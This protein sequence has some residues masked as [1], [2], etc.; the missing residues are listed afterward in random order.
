MTD[1]KLQQYFAYK[2]PSDS[3]ITVALVIVKTGHR[4]FHRINKKV[5]VVNNL[6]E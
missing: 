5:Y 2:T 6:P 1:I 3:D 4:V